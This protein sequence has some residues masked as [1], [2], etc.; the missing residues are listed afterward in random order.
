MLRLEDLDPQRCQPAYA[1]GMRSDL[2]WF[3]L[4]WDV[5]VLQSTLAAQHA[6][7]LDRLQALGVL[8]PCACSRTRIQALGRP[9]PDGG[10]AYDNACRHRAMPPGGWRACREPVRARLSGLDQD[11]SDG[12]IVVHDGSGIAIAQDPVRAM[13]DPVVRRRDGAVA[14]NLAVVVDDAAAGVTRVVRGRDIA[15]ST[16]TQIALHRLLGLSPPQY[17]HHPLLLQRN[18]DKLAK[19]HQSVGASVLRQIYTGPQLCGVLASGV[20]LWGERI[21]RECVDAVTPQQLRTDFT[22]ERV[23][24]VDQNVMW[25]GDRLVYL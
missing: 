9:A 22:W 5:C 17:H 6:A 14:Y 2:E 8:Y 16:P 24:T 23:T 18:G 3:G 12:V 10:W 21:G 25:T 13:G 15:P 4:D 11:S 7:A 20:G 1:D 19:R